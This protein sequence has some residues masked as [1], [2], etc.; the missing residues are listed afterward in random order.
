MEQEQQ[1]QLMVHQLQEPAVVAVAEVEMCLQDTT[2]PVELADLVVVV[3]AVEL[4]MLDALEQLTLVAVV[5]VVELTQEKMVKVEE[6][7]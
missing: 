1:V 6:V 3:Q 2:L 5:A 7:V 4:D